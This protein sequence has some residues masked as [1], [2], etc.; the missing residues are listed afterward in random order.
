[1][2]VA[3]GA[4]GTVGGAGAT[5][6]DW[7]REFTPPIKDTANTDVIILMRT[8]LVFIMVYLYCRFFMAANEKNHDRGQLDGLDLQDRET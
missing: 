3:E 1:M 6:A 4:A 5:G 2:E 8:D 7:A